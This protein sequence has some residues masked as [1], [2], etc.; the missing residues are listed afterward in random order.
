MQERIVYYQ[1]YKNKQN[2]LYQLHVIMHHLLC[3]QKID[4]IFGNCISKNKILFQ[5][6]KV[7]KPHFPNKFVNFSS[8]LY[9]KMKANRIS[10]VDSNYK[11]DRLTRY[12][13]FSTFSL[14][15]IRRWFISNP[16]LHYLISKDE[17]N[18]M[19]TFANQQNYRAFSL[20]SCWIGWEKGSNSLLIQSHA[21]H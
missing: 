1:V 6:S 12:L 4:H 2:Q 21:N 8:N 7:S 9:N 17:Q 5:L 3:P 13:Y 16:R 20:Y 10:T 19:P 14:E 11:S 18:C 15:T